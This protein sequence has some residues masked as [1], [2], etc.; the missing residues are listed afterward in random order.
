MKGNPQ[1]GS[2]EQLCV[3]ETSVSIPPFSDAKM[4]AVEDFEIT[5][6]ERV[7]KV[8][9]GNI[10]EAGRRAG[11]DRSN[12]RRLLRRYGIEPRKG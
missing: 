11:L 3:N 1:D 9:D 6:L 2:F 10:S 4:R 7:L 8:S 5:Y 12:F